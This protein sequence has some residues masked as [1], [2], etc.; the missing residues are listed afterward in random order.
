M[1]PRIVQENVITKE[2]EIQVKIT[3]DLNLNLNTGEF[4]VV[5][6]Q[7]HVPTHSKN[8]DEETSFLIPDFENSEK[9]AFGK[10]E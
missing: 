2:G 3:L 8:D 4:G 9:I 1:K 7:G 10:T 5:H 6:A